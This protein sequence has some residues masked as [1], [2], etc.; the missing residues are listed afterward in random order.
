MA[1][2]NPGD[3]VVLSSNSCGKCVNCEKGVPAYCLHFVKLYFGGTRLDGRHTM[4]MNDGSLLYA[5]YFGPSSFSRLAVVNSRCIVKVSS[6]APL[7]LYA[8]LGCGQQTGAG[9]IFN[10]LNVQPDA[11]VVIFGTG[12]VGMAA[13]MASKIREAR[14]I[15]RI[16]IDQK[17]LE[18]AQRLGATYILDGKANDIVERVQEISGANGVLYAV[19]TTG[20]PTVIERMIE[21]LGTLGQAVTIG[22]PAPG[23]QIKIDVFAHLTMGRRYIGCN[24]GDSIPQKASSRS[25]DNAV[26]VLINTLQMIP[27]FD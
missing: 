13:V 24:Q 7:D 2:I 11:T 26:Q 20:V 6:Q 8:P 21:S 19:D 3:G 10:S 12:A 23:S 17:R 27:L 22:A 5:N 25:Q 1:G 18:I 9:A 16:D 4:Q 15:I 14:V